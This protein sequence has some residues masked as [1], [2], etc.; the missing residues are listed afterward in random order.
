MICGFSPPCEFKVGPC[1]RLWGRSYSCAMEKK[2]KKRE[3]VFLLGGVFGKTAA[4]P[5]AASLQRALKERSPLLS[6]NSS[7][8]P[9][10]LLPL[11]FR[12]ASPASPRPPPSNR[13]AAKAALGVALGF[14]GNV[15]SRS[16]QS[17]HTR[18]KQSTRGEL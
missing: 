12:N 10:E 3:T 8:P 14:M 13:T 15:Q 6:L 5:T 17:T 18:S 7:I 4:L 1:F 2:K 9:N 16:P 11:A